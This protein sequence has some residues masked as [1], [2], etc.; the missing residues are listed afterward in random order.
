MSYGPNHATE[1]KYRLPMNHANR[2]ILVRPS[3]QVRVEVDLI[4][5]IP[6]PA[7]AGHVLRPATGVTDCGIVVTLA[8]QHVMERLTGV[9]SRLVISAPTVLTFKVPPNHPGIPFSL[10][11]ILGAVRELPLVV[12]PRAGEVAPAAAE[13]EFASAVEVLSEP[14][15]TAHRD[16]LA[17]RGAAQADS[18]SAATLG[19]PAATTLPA[20]ALAVS[21]RLDLSPRGNSTRFTHSVDPSDHN[22]RIEYWH[23]RLAVARLGGG[24]IERT[25]DL[26]GLRAKTASGTSAAWAADVN[27]ALST[28][29][30]DEAKAVANQATSALPLRASHV[31]LSPLGAT[32]DMRGEW[33]SAP[34]LKAWRHRTALGRDQ[35]ER[36]VLFGRLYPFGH[37]AIL[38]ITRE[39]AIIGVPNGSRT[40]LRARDRITVR[41]PIKTYPG[42]DKAGRQFPFSSVELL[43]T[44]T[45]NG[46]VE[47]L[48]GAARYIRVGV[49]TSKYAA[50]FKCL[51]TDRAGR[52]V[53]F[54]LPLAFV[55]EGFG[56]VSGQPT[57]GDLATAYANRLDLSIARLDGQT[58]AMADPGPVGSASAAP[59]PLDGVDVIANL[60][61]LGATSDSAFRPVFRELTGR[62]PGIE[63]F[64]QAPVPLELRY[65]SAFLDNGF[66]S[67]NPGEV[68]LRI[69]ETSPVLGLAER[70]V[71]GGIASALSM[72]VT[73]LSRRLGPV[74]G[75]VE[76]TVAGTFDPKQWF[77]SA[78]EGF[79]LLGIVKI[80]ELIPDTGPLADAPVISQGIVDGLRSQTVRW[81]TR[82]FAK[83]N[84]IPAP[85][86]FARLR[87]GSGGQP[88]LS[89]ESVVTPT[90]GG[91]VARTTC[92][93]SNVDL[94]FGLGPQDLVVVPFRK[95][96][97]TSIDGRKPDLDAELGRVQ[98][99]G[100]LAFVGVLAR[101]VDPAGFHDPPAL[102][103]L[104]DRVRSTFS[105][106]V[107]NVAVGMFSLEN[108]VFGAQLDVFFDQAPELALNFATFANPFRL[109]VSALG[110]GGYLA[111]AM[112]ASSGLVRLE[113]ALE[114]GAS[115][116]VDLGVAKGSVS[117][118]GGVYFLV[119]GNQERLTGYL[120]IRGELNV[121]GL[122][123]AAIELFLALTYDNGVLRGRAEMSVKVKLLFVSK[124]V[125][126]SME[127]T[128]AGSNGDPTFA[129]LMDP[130][131]DG[132][133]PWDTY[134]LAFA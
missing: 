37:E 66:G 120:R 107:P 25:A 5:L 57:F 11:G 12:D 31:I 52:P 99:L 63:R 76:Q 131:G 67:A 41:S 55:P 80:K 102:D 65:V 126:V 132:P 125:R 32:V 104:P 61:R 88:E 7:G 29:S 103:V 113:G 68:F 60:A 1:R 70:A 116:R 114:F 28:L 121:L 93:V 72:H 15:G 8:A 35:Y 58:I 94:C 40:G 123:S 13:A 10:T 112:S 47:T 133:R 106:P 86:G 38:T 3:D 97:F 42:N 73:G 77:K 9:P 53:R 109:T 48:I 108:I 84:M 129:Q 62:V 119:E 51:A 36:R 111:L 22:G 95:L 64:T 118:M 130:G 117:A 16:D 124:T 54:E 14:T 44:E 128:F 6:M 46:T 127:R 82:L 71:N 21:S 34:M 87:K 78:L 105:A 83:Q 69:A 92:T 101:L 39:R 59:R 24:V 2:F 98:F 45:P 19:A 4:G 30:I 49:G 96:S 75:I 50:H 33:P 81:T 20:S 18:P 122:I 26:I 17:K 134:C 56:T 27:S 91:A 79:T 110:G 74:G 90:A 115:M 89:I 43:T 23:T 85:G 100:A